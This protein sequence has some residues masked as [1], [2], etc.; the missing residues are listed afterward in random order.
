MDPTH[1]N[2]GRSEQSSFQENSAENGEQ[3]SSLVEEGPIS[4]IPESLR[5]I[6]GSTVAI[7][8]APL[9]EP[10]PAVEEFSTSTLP[11]EEGP[12]YGTDAGESSSGSS[13]AAIPSS[14]SIRG[15]VSSP[16]QGA[17]RPTF[18]FFGV[19]SALS[20]F[21]DISTKV[22]AEMTITERGFEPIRVIGESFAI[23]LAYNKGG[24]WGLFAGADDAM[25]TPFFLGVSALAV[26]FIISLYSRLQPTQTALKWGLPLVLGGALGNLSDRITRSQVI[27]F[28]DYKSDWVLSLNTF[29]HRYVQTWSLTD[30]WPTFNVADIAICV[31]VALMAVDMFTHRGQPSREGPSPDDDSQRDTTEPSSAVS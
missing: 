20:L 23:T 6:V 19:V 3:V 5:R 16:E 7:S 22:W 1:E 10:P 9:S 28:I 14:A 13:D 11:P 30:H 25:R 15:Q 17:G 31:G 18:L 21:A 12:Q 27:D 26:F 8:E 2:R 29:V 24:A 4:N